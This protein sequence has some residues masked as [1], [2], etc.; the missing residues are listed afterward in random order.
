MEEEEEEKVEK[1]KKKEEK[2]EEEKEEEATAAAIGPMFP[3]ANR[4]QNVLAREE[5]TRFL[6]R[7]AEGHF[8]DFAK[9]RA[10]ARDSFRYTSISARVIVL[11]NGN[12]RA[13]AYI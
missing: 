1:K 6:R 10:L 5:I 9:A 12:V 8:V 7:A 4:R 13:R 2:A 11:D 3:F